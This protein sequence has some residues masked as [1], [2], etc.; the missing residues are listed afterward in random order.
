[1]L[2]P[3]TPAVVL[4]VCAGCGQVNGQHHPSVRTC[5]VGTVMLLRLGRNSACSS[6]HAA[7]LERTTT[8]S[9]TL[10]AA[11]ACQGAL[12]AMPAAVLGNVSCNLAPGECWLPLFVC[13][14]S[15]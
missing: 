6:T 3:L 10:P 11:A 5:A 9:W 7:T 2:M 15:A 14:S 8:V 4:N 12:T 13:I 1:M